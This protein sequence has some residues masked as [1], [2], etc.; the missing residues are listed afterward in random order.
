MSSIFTAKIDSID[1]ITEEL[2]HMTP[3]ADIVVILST[4][5]ALFT[6]IERRGGV[7]GVSSDMSRTLRI[8]KIMGKLTEAELD[9]KVAT[10]RVQAAETMKLLTKSIEIFGAELNHRVPLH[11]PIPLIHSAKPSVEIEDEKPLEFIGAELDALC[12]RS[13]ENIHVTC[14]DEETPSAISTIVATLKTAYE[15]GVAHEHRR[16]AKEYNRLRKQ[17]KESQESVRHLLSAKK[18][19]DEAEAEIS[20]ELGGQTLEDLAEKF[21]DGKE[22]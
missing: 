8:D 12:E 9:E 5:T 4:S 17:L 7:D 14:R 20:A 19:F 2:A 16:L 18:E 1:D 3:T 10:A 6:D 11:A 15:N 22:D 21:H 13:A